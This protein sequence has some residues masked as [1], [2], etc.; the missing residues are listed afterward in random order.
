MNKTKAIKIKEDL[1]YLLIKVF[2][3]SSEDLIFHLMD[4]FSYFPQGSGK[5]QTNQH[6]NIVHFYIEKVSLTNLLS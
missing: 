5:N 2:Q 6:Q 3:H 1:K 4:N